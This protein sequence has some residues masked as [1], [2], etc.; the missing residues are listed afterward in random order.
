[1]QFDAVYR[2]YLPAVYRYVRARVGATSDAE[3]ITAAAFLDAMTSLARYQ[4]QGRFPAWLF[5]IARRRITA[6][7][8]RYV[9]REGK[10]ASVEE[11][12]L[13]RMPDVGA[14]SST[15]RMADQDLL[16]RAMTAHLSADQHEALALRFYGDLPIAEIARVMGKGESAV[17][18]LLHRGLGRL[19]KAMVDVSEDAD[20]GES[21]SEGDATS[22]TN[23]RS[24][25]K[26]AA[27]G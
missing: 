15:A 19:R 13:R 17:K 9:R 11:E 4:E 25:N 1:M 6:H 5:T 2:R 20:G 14:G 26:G 7:R 27:H 23:S 16:Q 8:R 22:S 3:D 12:S 24:A 10:E 18:M 21:T